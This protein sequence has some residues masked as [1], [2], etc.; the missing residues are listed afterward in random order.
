[1]RTLATLEHYLAT[2]DAHGLQ[3][4]LYHSASI[5]TTLESGNNVHLHMESNYPW[6][7]DTRL[8]I[9][10]TDG[11]TWRVSLRIPAWASG[12]SI[13]VNGTPVKA[14]IEPGQYAV[15]ERTWQAGDRVEVLLPVTPGLVEA[16]PWIDATRSS[17]AIQRGPILYCVEQVD[18]DEP[19]P[20]LQIDDSAPLAA[21]WDADLLGGVI[22]VKASGVKPDISPW[23]GQL[24]RPVNGRAEPTYQSTLITAIP[25]FAWGNRG[26]NAMRVWIPRK[27]AQL[28]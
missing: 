25:Y 23:Q 20:A 12:A 5:Q 14:L 28:E 15:I 9:N 26:A 4:H 1:M 21:E 8:V 24:Y 13:Q 7:G 22:A 11:S 19:V 3:I 16:H 17:V 10:E 6:E 18:Q 27:G 2:H